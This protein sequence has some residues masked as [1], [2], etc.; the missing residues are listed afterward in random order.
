MLEEEVSFW[1]QPPDPFRSH[2]F[3]TSHLS[4]LLRDSQHNLG[5]E[6]RFSPGNM[7]GSKV[8]HSQEPAKNQNS[9]LLCT[10]LFPF[11]GHRTWG[12]VGCQLF[13]MMMQPRQ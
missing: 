10:R 4:V 3:P 5:T 7:Q 12:Q 13:F 11:A 8:I 2:L 1:N 9:V 6:I